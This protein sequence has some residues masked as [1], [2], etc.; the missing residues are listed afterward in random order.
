MWFSD[1]SCP[2][3]KRI[4]LLYQ[5]EIT[6][7]LRKQKILT[8]NMIFNSLKLFKPSKLKTTAP[9]CVYILFTVHTDYIFVIK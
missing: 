4:N 6:K 5:I 7:Y 9:L 2:R 3:T 1:K 8:G